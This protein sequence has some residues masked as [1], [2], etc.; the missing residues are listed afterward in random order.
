MDFCPFPRSVLIK[1][2]AIFHV[3][4]KSVTED[5]GEEKRDYGHF[6]QVKFKEILVELEKEN[7]LLLL[8]VLFHIPKSSP[9]IYLFQRLNGSFLIFITRSYSSWCFN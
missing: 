8:K 7:K 1:N 5:V 9:R 6:S 4:S 2:T 3:L